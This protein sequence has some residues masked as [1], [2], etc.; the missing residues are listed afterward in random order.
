M[1]LAINGQAQAGLRFDERGLIP[2]IVQDAHT[3]RVLTLAY[4]NAESLAKTLASGETWFFS[5][6]RQELWHK[7]ETSGHTQRVLDVYVDCDGDAL[8]VQVEPAGPACHTGATSCFHTGLAAPQ[9]AVASGRADEHGG[10][11]TAG[12]AGKRG[13]VGSADAAMRD[14]AVDVLLQL[15]QRV[16]QRHVERPPGAYTTYLFDK[17]L[18]KILKKVGEEATEVIIGAKNA[19]AAEVTYE[20]ADLLYHL[21]VL[22]RQQDI[23]LADVFRELER[24]YHGREQVVKGGK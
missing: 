14:A 6:S 24:R 4:M 1:G 9:A 15:E 5:R 18:D 21:L 12:V 11:G 7:G 23:A 10:D 2:A 16:L 19:D 20:A 13:A 3:K 17:G 22:L 8:V